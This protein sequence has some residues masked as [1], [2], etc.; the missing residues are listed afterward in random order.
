[1]R[2][3]SRARFGS[4]HHDTGGAILHVDVQR[5]F[6]HACAGFQYALLDQLV[7]T[8]CDVL[9]TSDSMFSWRAALIRG[10]SEGLFHYHDGVVKKVHLV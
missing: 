4:S 2:N 10:E 5:H 7:L 1:M 9:V 6:R 8:R 3:M